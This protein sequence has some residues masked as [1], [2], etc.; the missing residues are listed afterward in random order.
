VVVELSAQPVVCCFE[1][2]DGGDAGKVESSGQQFPDVTE[3]IEVG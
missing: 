3:P 1:L 2:E